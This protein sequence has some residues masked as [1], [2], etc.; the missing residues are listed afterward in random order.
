MEEE[1][2]EGP[3][4]LAWRLFTLLHVAS[5]LPTSSV[6]TIRAVDRTNILFARLDRQR[7]EI[8]LEAHRPRL[9]LFFLLYFMFWEM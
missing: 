8:S 9:S 2:K 4:A 3:L 6:H 5:S 7:K 1:E